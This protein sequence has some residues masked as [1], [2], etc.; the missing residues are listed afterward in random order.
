MAN[1]E[2]LSRLIRAVEECDAEK[3]TQVRLSRADAV[4]IVSAL[5]GGE[6]DLPEEEEQEGKVQFYCLYCGKSFRT[7]AREDPECLRKWN[8]HTWYADCPWCGK[9]ARQTDM[10]WR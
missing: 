4:R 5:S 8:Y 9:E 2:L 7:E 6:T 10:Y 3:G 1:E